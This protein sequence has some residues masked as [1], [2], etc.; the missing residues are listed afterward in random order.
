MKCNWNN[1]IKEP[2]SSG[3]TNYRL[4]PATQPQIFRPPCAGERSSGRAIDVALRLGAKLRPLRILQSDLGC[5]DRCAASNRLVASHVSRPPLIPSG[6][7]PME[8]RAETAAAY[9][10]E[11]SIPAFLGKVDRGIYSAPARH[12]G[13][14][15]K[16]HRR[17]LDQDIARRHGLHWIYQ[18]FRKRNGANLMP[19]RKPLGWPKLMV[20]KRLKNSVVAYYWAAPTWAKKT[21]VPV[22]A[23]ALGNDYA[24]AKLRC[25]EILN[26]QFDAWRT[27]SATRPLLEAGQCSVP[28]TG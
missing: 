24:T 26:P 16:W 19:R 28:L 3:T 9:C 8:M 7:W 10:D 21:G 2:R 13:C 15:P 23:E 1:W 22:V 20:A 27:S 6:S 11:P 14:L 5:L 25:D 18:Q 12:K 17:K 4:V